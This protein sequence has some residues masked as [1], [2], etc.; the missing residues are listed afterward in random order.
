[1]NKKMRIYGAMNA[2]GEMKL[3]YNVIIAHTIFVSCVLSREG[4][5]IKTE[6]SNDLLRYIEVN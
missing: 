4:Y 6:V 5:R 1:M 2:I 3:D